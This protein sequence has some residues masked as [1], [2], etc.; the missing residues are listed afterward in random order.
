[1][2]LLYTRDGSITL[3]LFDGE[4]YVIPPNATGAQTIRQGERVE[5]RT[6]HLLGY[7][8]GDN[9]YLGCCVGKDKVLVED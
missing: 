4:T 5:D 7:R 2:N 3:T 8:L 9:P 6:T 1:M